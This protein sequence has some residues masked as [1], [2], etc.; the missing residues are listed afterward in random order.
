MSKLSKKIEGQIVSLQKKI[1][2][3]SG[4][5]L[6]NTWKRQQEQKH[7]D[8]QIEQ[9]RT[10]QQV[11]QYL[12]EEDC[13]RYLTTLEEALLTGTIFELMRYYLAN[14]KYGEEN[15]HIITRKIQFPESDEAFKKRLQKAGIYDTRSLYSAVNEFERLLQNSVIAPNPKAEKLRDMVFEARLSQ[16]GD[17]QFTPE[18]MADHLIKLAGIS[19]ESKVLEPSAGIGSIAD[20]VKKVT[21]N[22]DCVELMRSF[23]EILRLKEHNVIGGNL[24]DLEAEPVYD[25]VIMNP[26]F[27]EECRHIRH[28]FGF[29]KPGGTLVSVCC[30]RIEASKR[31]E[32]MEFQE[33]LCRRYYQIHETTGK[34]EMTETN[35]KILVIPKEVA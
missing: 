33:W 6:T 35:V 7:R 13:C 18:P 28:A 1:D 5:Y 9:Y 23:Q 11:L 29:L 25:V 16:S 8:K 26:P 27:S 31:R 14:K 34:F 15:P 3:L 12:A 20:R 30:S 21:S 17:T 10:Y 32:Y 19:A 2:A 4:D 24:F 22:V